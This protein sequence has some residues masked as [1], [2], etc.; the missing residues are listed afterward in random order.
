MALSRRLA[1]LG[2]AASAYSLM[3]A[4]SYRLTR[5]VVPVQA[6]IDRLTILHVS[7]THL[8]GP[9]SP[10]VP[11]LERLPE[12][13]GTTPDLVF[14]TGDLIESDKG[15]EPIVAALS[16]LE[17]QLGRYYV[18]GSHDYFQSENPS[19]LKYVTGNR[20][21]PVAS[22][23]A[24]ED[25]EGGLSDKGW[26]SA[27]NLT[28]Q[29]DAPQGR[30][31]ISGVADPYLNWHTTDHIHRAPDE[32]LALGLVHAPDVVSEW[33]LNGFDLVFAGHTHGGQ[34]RVPPIGSIVTNSDLP[35]ALAYGLHR[36]GSG[37]LHVSPGLGTSHYAPIRFCCP[38]EA[39]LLELVGNKGYGLGHRPSKGSE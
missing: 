20:K 34:I 17:A 11:F 12:L 5:R 3:E 39:T 15:I 22:R 28:H 9:E 29:I 32:V 37:W 25:L 30:I 33:L 13:V 16:R 23:A 26:I 4:R 24:T 14:V 2:A 8:T 27:Q 38:P 35:A 10:L 18:L 7:D 19:F 31:R 1:A 21:V 36:I 6:G